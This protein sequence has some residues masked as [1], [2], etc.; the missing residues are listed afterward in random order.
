MDEITWDEPLSEDK[1]KELLQW[2]K[3]DLV[4]FVSAVLDNRSYYVNTKIPRHLEFQQ[5][6][7]EVLDA[8]NILAEDNHDKRVIRD[9]LG[10]QTWIMDDLYPA[11]QNVRRTLNAKH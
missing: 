8:W 10:L 7:Y 5:R 11:I 9:K 2:N 3:H 4:E 6:L 1:K